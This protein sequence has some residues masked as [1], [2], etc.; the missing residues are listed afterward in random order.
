[1]GTPAVA[2]VDGRHARSARTREAIVD[3]FLALLEG[4]DIKP[5]AAVIAAKAG[6]SV[7]SVFQHFSDLE[8]LLLA[9]SDRHTDRVA[10][11]FTGV[12]Y[13]GD[14][15]S[16]IE[17]FAGAR[18]RLFEIIA[19]VRRAAMLQ[20]P[21]SKVVASRMELARTLHRLDIE[22]AFA[23]ELEAAG[24]QG[25][26]ALAPALQSA[27]SFAAWDEMRRSAG[28]YIDEATAVLRRTVTAL[29]R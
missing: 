4:G 5:T 29:L 3:A 20:E 7:R 9:V 12:M 17:E 25:D 13:D 16:R 15:P 28:L 23:S 27:A 21:F 11:L 26:T 6:L 1:M 22:R 19:P 14:L 8:D 10:M 18:A 2:S 24:E